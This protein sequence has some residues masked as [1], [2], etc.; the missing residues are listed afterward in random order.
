MAAPGFEMR[1]FALSDLHVDYA[2]NMRRF[3]MLSERDFR[4]DAL[5]LAGDV[6]DSLDKLETVF[7][8][9]RS[10][11]A[12]VFFVPGNHE[13][14]VRR[15][16]AKDSIQKF[17][18]I[19]SLCESLDVKTRATSIP[20]TLNETGVWIVP[21]FSWYVKPEEGSSTL[22]VEKGRNDAGL[23]MWADDYLTK[24]HGLA[25]G[26]G[27]ADFFIDMNR[28]HVERQ[29]DA[30][31]ISFSHFLPRRELMFANGRQPPPR[32][33]AR[34]VG[35]GAQFNFSR[36]AGSSRLDEQIRALGSSVHVYGHQHRNRNLVIDGVRYISNCLGY[37][38]ERARGETGSENPGPSLVW[39]TGRYSKLIPVENSP[40]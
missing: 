6:T 32:V 23:S 19:L 9:A 37:P 35:R 18:V 10:K 30:P 7:R 28:A 36:V 39:D 14:W 22:F 1:V 13:L 12:A 33:S 15:D 4:E 29:Y 21:L 2:E 16:E 20:G 24:W 5:I 11:F 38:H 34:V 31:I 3:E 40:G 17:H 8:Q 27:V 26:A 25:P